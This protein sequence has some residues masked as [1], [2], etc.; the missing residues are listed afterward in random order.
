MPTSWHGH[1]QSL[2]ATPQYWGHHGVSASSSA[3]HSPSP[4]LCNELDEDDDIFDEDNTHPCFDDY[5]Q[6]NDDD[7]PDPTKL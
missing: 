7:I 5:D 1:Y 6:E 3:S 4:S 2:L